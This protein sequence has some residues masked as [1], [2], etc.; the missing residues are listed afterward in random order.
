MRPPR[1]VTITT[2]SA[3]LI[4]LPV[5]NDAQRRP[6]CPGISGGVFGMMGGMM[7][8]H[9]RPTYARSHQAPRVANAPAQSPTEGEPPA[10]PN[11]AIAAPMGQN[12]LFWPQLSDDVFDYVFWPS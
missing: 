4:A 9:H 5:V 11:T 1:L 12:G 6:R 2:I 3:V 7:G 10:Q 8:L